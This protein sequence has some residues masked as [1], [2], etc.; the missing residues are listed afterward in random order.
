MG[1]FQLA[2]TFFSLTACAE[3]FFSGERPLDEFFSR[4]I[5]LFF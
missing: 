1:N 4:Q 2:Q 3:I 5:L